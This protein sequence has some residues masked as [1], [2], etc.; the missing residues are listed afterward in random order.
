MKQSL[1]EIASRIIVCSAPRIESIVKNESIGAI[2]TACEEH[3][4]CF[5]DFNFDA[6]PSHSTAIHKDFSNL[7]NTERTTA[8]LEDLNVAKEFLNTMRY[9]ETLLIHCHA[10]F[11][12]S[13][14]FTLVLLLYLQGDEYNIDE[15][16]KVVNKIAEREISISSALNRYKSFTDSKYPDLTQA[17]LDYASAR[18]FERFE[19]NDKLNGYLSRSFP[20]AERPTLADLRELSSRFDIPIPTA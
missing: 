9:D 2:I 18:Y 10:G 15:T 12:N 20:R 6:L 3:V 8:I 4:R 1:E 14:S 17:V 16:I 5:S 7:S 13:P 11:S 19:D